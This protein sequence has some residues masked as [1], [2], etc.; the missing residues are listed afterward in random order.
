MLLRSWILTVAL[1]L[2][3][4]GLGCSGP[5]I[6]VTAGPNQPSSPPAKVAVLDLGV[7]SAGAGG[8]LLDGCA[9]GVLVAGTTVIERSRVKA[10]LDEKSQSRSGEQDPA[11]YQ[12]LG[13]LLGV[14]SFI[15]GAAMGDAIT[16]KHGFGNVIQETWVVKEMSA[17][18]VNAASGA[19]TRIVQAE[20]GFGLGQ[21]TP[22]EMAERVCAAV[23]RGRDE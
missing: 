21:V 18:L 5:K 3:S 1:W 9:K 10:V 16:V 17:R 12:R 2:V 13:E 20:N 11:F 6:V 4:G 22:S 15:V 7:D 23:V 14:D 8:V 19:V